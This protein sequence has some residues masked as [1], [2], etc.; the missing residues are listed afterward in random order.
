MNNWYTYTLRHPNGVVFYT[1]KGQGDYWNI[2]EQKAKRGEKV[3]LTMII[4]GIW[5][6]GQQVLKQKEREH[7]S[8]EEAY[9]HQVELYNK[10]SAA[11]PEMCYAGAYPR[12]VGHGKHIGASRKAKGYKPSQAALDKMSRS[13]TGVKY[14]E[15]RLARNAERLKNPTHLNTPEAIAKREKTRKGAK[16]SEA[17]KARMSASAK[18]RFARMS[19]EEKANYLQI[20]VEAGQEAAKQFTK[21]TVIE[22]TVEATL[23]ASGVEYIKQFQV[24]Y[25]RCDFYIPE[26]NTIIEAHGCYWHQCPVCGY[27]NHRT[28]EIR[29]KDVRKIAYLESKGYT[30]NVIWEHSMEGHKTRK[31]KKTD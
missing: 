4:Q 20:W 12:P 10:Y 19:E 2:H 23:K 8:E 7:L 13:R 21:D 26:T 15:E 16:R 22:K 29:A 18:R 11:N 5:N 6:Q 28:E 9:A 14:S 3:K 24:S 1:G 30:V 31:P 25:Y 17:S 27:N